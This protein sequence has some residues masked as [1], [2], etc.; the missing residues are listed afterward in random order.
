MTSEPAPGTTGSTSS[1]G[2]SPDQGSTPDGVPLQIKMQ[3]MSTE[4][5]SLLATRSL[6]WNETFMRAG[7]FLST[8]SFAVV[9]LALV[10]QASDFGQDFRVFALIILPVVL[11]LGIGTALRMDSSNYNDLVTVVGMNRIR[12][13]YAEQSPDLEKYFVMGTTDDM[14]GIY[15][16]M[17]GIPN[18][19]FFT[20]V[21]SA[22]PFVVSVLNAVLL[23]AIVA[24]AAV[25]LELDQ[26]LATAAGIAAFFLAMALTMVMVL[27]TIGAITADYKPLFPGTPE[28][29][30]QD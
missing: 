9:A 3:I 1:D 11:F 13:W 14:E 21:F 29:K 22:S 10:G 20:E 2:N 5:W 7:M 16:T 18:R 23:A 4:H 30:G 19:H 24:L 17:G 28:S 27:R 6:A 15:K 25:Q 12:A 26:T 8:L